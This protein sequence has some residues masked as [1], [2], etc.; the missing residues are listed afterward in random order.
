MSDF[1]KCLTG[2][3]EVAKKTTSITVNPQAI[4]AIVFAVVAAV[5]AAKEKAGK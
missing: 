3:V 2:S 4:G 5:I 1:L